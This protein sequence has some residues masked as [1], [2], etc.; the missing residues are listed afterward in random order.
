MELAIPQRL[1]GAIDAR[2]MKQ[3]GHASGMLEG[4]EVQQ[5]TLETLLPIIETTASV[6]VEALR[7]GHKVLVFG[8][9]GSAAEAQHFT[10]E[11]VGRYKAERAPFP[12]SR[13]R[14]TAALLP[15]SATITV[16]T[17]SSHVRCVR[18]LSP[19]MWQWV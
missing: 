15:A 2:G 14:Q 18:W 4:L 16:L 1:W 17:K 12:A 11:L 3:R 6:L 10:G 9:G 13:F 5:Q 19:V 8:N 7:A